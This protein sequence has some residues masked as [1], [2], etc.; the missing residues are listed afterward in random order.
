MAQIMLVIFHGHVVYAALAS[1]HAAGL[2]HQ[3][4]KFD[5][6][7]VDSGDCSFRAGF[8]ATISLAH[9][10]VVC[11]SLIGANRFFQCLTSRAQRSTFLQR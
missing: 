1:L 7:L 5:I 8:G 3:D 4:L 11:P 2:A 10:R 9:W 6:L